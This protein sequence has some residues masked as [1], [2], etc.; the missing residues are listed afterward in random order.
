[1]VAFLEREL[2]AP[3]KADPM[4]TYFPLREVSSCEKGKCIEYTGIAEYVGLFEDPKDT[5]PK[6]IIETRAE[7]KERRRREK[8][9]LLAYKVEQG[10]AQWNPA[11]N[12]NATEDPYKTLFVARINYETSE[13]RLKR[14]F[15]TYGK[16]KKLAMIHDLNGKPRGYAFIEYSDKSEMSNAYKRADGTKVDGRRLIVD[17][18]RGRTQKSWLPRRLGGGKGDTRRARESRAAMEEREALGLPPLDGPRDRDRDRGDSPRTRDSY[19]DHDRNG[20]S[21]HRSRSRDRGHR[22][23]G[24]DRDRFRDRRENGHGRDDRRSGFRGPPP[25]YGRDRR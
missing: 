2:L 18:E 5:P 8:E 7:K 23:R 9:E 21:R 15:E 1:M 11:E 22:D 14:E 6:P 20:S 4:V 12:P 3:F 25:P 16:I 19:R 24:Y 10:I 13:N 17:Y